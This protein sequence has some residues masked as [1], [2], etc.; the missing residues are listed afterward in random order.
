MGIVVCILMLLVC[1]L[2]AAADKGT[3]DEAKS[4][5][6]KAIA[7]YK[8]AGKDKAFAEFSN[9]TGA[10]VSKDLY[11]FV[12]DL[13]GICVA[14]GQN[15][16]LVGKSVITLTDS[17]G[18]L[19]IKD[20]VDAAKVKKSGWSDYKWSN[21]VTKKIEQKSTYFEKEGNFI[22]GCGIYK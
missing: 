11:I 6:K 15:K 14:H 7:L 19:F 8:E 12:I 22:F 18:K 10:F 2:A 4:L 13:Q 1:G 21:K 9:P 17:T 16:A 20:L 5:L 3:P